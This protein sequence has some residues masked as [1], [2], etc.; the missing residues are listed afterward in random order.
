MAPKS[1]SRRVACSDVRLLQKITDSGLVV[2]HW[3]IGSWIRAVWLKA[4]EVV[5]ALATDGALPWASGGRPDPCR[6]GTC[7]SPLTKRG[8]RDPCSRRRGISYRR[9]RLLCSTIEIPHYT[10]NPRCPTSSSQESNCLYTQKSSTWPVCLQFTSFPP[11]EPPWVASWG[12]FP[13]SL[14]PNWV[15]TPSSVREA[16]F[17]FP[18]FVANP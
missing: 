16:V 7:Y 13:V 18:Y 2:A 10:D 6:T 1:L 5:L 9:H 3:R 4:P 14:P 12:V 15:P 8:A 17:C 11:R